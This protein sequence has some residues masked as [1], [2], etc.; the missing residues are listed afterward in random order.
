MHYIRSGDR[1]IFQEKIRKIYRKY[2][3]GIKIGEN[4]NIG[5]PVPGVLD[6]RFSFGSLLSFNEVRFE[7]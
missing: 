5:I 1:E 4:M 6:L 2:M 3:L 7:K